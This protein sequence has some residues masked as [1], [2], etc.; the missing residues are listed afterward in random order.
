MITSILLQAATNYSQFLPMI[1]IVIVFYFFMIRPQMNKQKEQKK[2][3]EAL[4]KGD[5]VVTT[6]GLHGRIVDI[7]DDTVV[8]EV[9]SGARLRFD[10]SA[11]SLDAS[12][13]WNDRSKKA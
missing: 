12:K 4:N 2:F 3:V 13:A 7:N 10:R 1:L 11:I 9:E 8:L 5:K 6:A